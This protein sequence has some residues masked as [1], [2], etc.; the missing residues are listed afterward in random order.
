MGTLVVKWF[1]PICSTGKYWRREALGNPPYFQTHWLHSIFVK[2]VNR[3]DFK[4]SKQIS[5]LC[6]SIIYEIELILSK[7]VNAMRTLDRK[8]LILQYCLHKMKKTSF[9]KWI[10]QTIQLYLFPKSLCCLYLQLINYLL[11]IILKLAGNHK[12]CQPTLYSLQWRMRI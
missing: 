6:L 8:M 7:Y 1:K 4:I 11:I 3:S 12:G 10:L 5:P 9:Q 2:H